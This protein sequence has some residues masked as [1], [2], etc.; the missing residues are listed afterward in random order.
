MTTSIPGLDTV[1][2]GGLVAGGSYV[3]Q[4]RPGAGK[5]ILA[6][7]IAFHR[8]GLGEKV[9]FVT[10][11]SEAHEHLFKLLSTLSFFD[12][13]QIGTNIQFVSAYR[14]MVTEGLDGIVHIIR[15]E[16]AR[17]KRTLFVLDG[18]LNAHY[19][20][21][22]RDQIKRFVAELQ[23][24]AGFGGCTSL[25]LASARLSDDSPEHTMV[26]GVIDLAD[27]IVGARSVRRIEVRKMRGS[28]MLRGLHNFE[29]TDSGIVVYP[30][31][32]AAYKGMA[33]PELA[34]E[35]LSSGVEDLDNALG[36]G[37]RSGSF[38]LLMGPSGVGKTM[39]GLNFIS[40]ASHA[41]PAL[42][43]G[44]YE[45]PE[46]LKEKATAIGLDFDPPIKSGTLKVEWNPLGEDLLD[47]LGERLLRQVR[48]QGTRRLFID[49][50][51]AF[52]RAAVSQ[53]RIVEFFSALSNQLR[54]NGTTTVASWEMPDLF[55]GSADTPAPEISS[56]VE[57]IILLRF[58][59][60]YARIRRVLAIM[61]VRDCDYDTAVQEIRFGKD[62]L[63][64][65]PLHPAI[66]D[67]LDGS[68]QDAAPHQAR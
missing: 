36:G 6:N 28:S 8:A 49:G 31:L 68:A 60:H 11:L 16:I 13:S 54:A 10:L 37:F 43:F 61:K 64:L 46:R 19:Q 18:L 35:M 50:A 66:K 65:A 45:G 4:G 14:E 59:E 5:T 12:R 20:A 22:S 67:T 29:I 21:Q 30:R 26:D 17:E 56:I 23:G 62:G 27:E 57:N 9:L 34:S 63:K 1:L 33:E 55:G 2:N 44:F 42:F 15:R 7:Q 39:L 40:R 58:A 32:E 38:T 51:G 53:S 48:E 25:F 47:R 3:L 41:E 52:K 24:H